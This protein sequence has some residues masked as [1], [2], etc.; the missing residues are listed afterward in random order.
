[1]NREL[2]IAYE[3]LQANPNDVQKTEGTRRL[4]FQHIDK[5]YA[6]MIGELEQRDFAGAEIGLKVLCILDPNNRQYRTA[7]DSLLN[8]RKKLKETAIAQGLTEQSEYYRNN[9]N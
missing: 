6:A 1:M 8:N 3:K 5:I 2:S 4:L 7:H 9:L